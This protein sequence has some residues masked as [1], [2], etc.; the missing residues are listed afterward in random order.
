L[1]SLRKVTPSKILEQERLDHRVIIE[2]PEETVLEIFC[3]KRVERDLK[4]HD[5]RKLAGEV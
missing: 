1:N 4:L 2:G 5:T 3:L